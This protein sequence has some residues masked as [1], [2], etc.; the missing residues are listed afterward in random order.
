MVSRRWTSRRTS[1]GGGKLFFQASSERVGRVDGGVDKEAF[2]SLRLLRAGP[3]VPSR[4]SLGYRR[5]V[6]GAVCRFDLGKGR[7]PSSVASVF[8]GP[9]RRRFSYFILAR[10]HIR[11]NSLVPNISN[12]VCDV[13]PEGILRRSAV[14][15]DEI[16][17]I[18]HL[19]AG[20]CDHRR[21]SF[22]LSPDWRLN[23]VQKNEEKNGVS[24]KVNRKR[25][26]STKP[27]VPRG[28]FGPSIIAPTFNFLFLL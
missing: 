17:R 4:P 27:K 2:I 25:F 9:Y 18:E 15:R 12:G 26:F 19:G 13:L 23:G 16:E 1:N 7:A 8:V 11:K 3:T 24:S 22:L 14:H 21:S 6:F 5:T 28:T 20:Y 10:R